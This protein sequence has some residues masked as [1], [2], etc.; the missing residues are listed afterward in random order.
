MVRGKIYPYPTS[1]DGEGANTS[2]ND[3]WPRL[4]SVATTRAGVNGLFDM[5]G[6]A[7]EWLADRDG[8][9]ALTAGGSWWYG[10]EKMNSGSMLWKPAE[11]YAVYVS[12]RCIYDDPSLHRSSN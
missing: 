8:E 7:W 4:A 9:T 12:F 11:F 5:G 1:S 3:P 6:N 2:E 10:R